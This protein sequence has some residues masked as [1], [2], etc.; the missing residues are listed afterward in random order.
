MTEKEF[1]NRVTWMTFLLSVTVVLV[2]S[3]NIDLLMD[4]AVQTGAAGAVARFETLVSAALPAPAVT[5]FFLVSAFLFFRNV[6]G[7]NLLQKM[8]RRVGSVLIPYIVWTTLYYMVFVIGGN[9][10]LLRG[11]LGR[12]SVAFSLPGLAEAIINYSYN[13]VLWYLK[14]LIILIAGAPVIYLVVSGILRGGVYLLVLLWVASR[15]TIIPILN[16][17]AL[18]YYSLGAYVALHGKYLVEGRLGGEKS[19]LPCKTVV[20]AAGV[21]VSILLYRGAGRYGSILMQ[22]LYAVAAP[23]TLWYAL[24]ARLPEAKPY[25]KFSLFL[26]CFHFLPVRGLNKIAGLLLPHNAFS[27]AA[28]YV[29]MPAACVLLAWGLSSFMKRKIPP[30]WKLL[31]GGR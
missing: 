20:A 8:T 11:F 6:S 24:P 10:P 23:V 21:I 29:L 25:M 22:I 14:Q 17:D 28:V 15:G 26:Y 9:S 19:G 27:A 12:E 5:G 13:P 7:E 18:F 31:S 4:T 30:L 16:L 2:H 3:Y 1:H